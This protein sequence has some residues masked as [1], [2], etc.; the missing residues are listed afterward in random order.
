MFGS[1]SL[2]SMLLAAVTHS[3]VDAVHA[4]I[5]VH[6]CILV[7]EWSTLLRMLLAKHF[8]IAEMLQWYD[9]PAFFLFFACAF[10]LQ[11]LVS[12]IWSLDI[13]MEMNME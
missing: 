3:V 6:A 2:H 5:P 7:H 12:R 4:C 10:A 11:R 8:I 13:A 1:S 9:Q